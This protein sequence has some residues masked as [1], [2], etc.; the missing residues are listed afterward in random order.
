MEIV[1]Y[2]PNYY[3][4][5]YNYNGSFIELAKRINF[6][7]N[8]VYQPNLLDDIV[9]FVYLRNTSVKLKLFE[10]YKTSPLI[11]KGIKNYIKSLNVGFDV[12][13]IF[14]VNKYMKIGDMKYYIRDIFEDNRYTIESLKIGVATSQNTTISLGLINL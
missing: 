9:G 3:L 2:N 14:K 13:L 7:R 1:S 11:K 10:H 12:I 4:C 5:Q 6:V 8:N